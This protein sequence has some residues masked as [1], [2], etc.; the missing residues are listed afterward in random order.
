MIAA[1]LK[2]KLVMTFQTSPFE[3]IQKEAS[4][5]HVIPVGYKL[6]DKACT[7][8]VEFFDLVE[9]PKYPSSQVPEEQEM[10]LERKLIKKFQQILDSKE[11]S[12]W[13]ENDESLLE[14]FAKRYNLVI[15]SFIET[16]PEPT[17][18]TTTTTVAVET[19][20]TTTTSVQ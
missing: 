12:T 5:F 18:T 14:I 13:G 7:F 16:D 3:T 10:V 1:K 19:T 17:T 20:S 8:H 9:V 11:Y 4:Y 15:E 6:G 2:N